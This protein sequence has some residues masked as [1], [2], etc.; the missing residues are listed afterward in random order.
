VPST[1]GFLLPMSVTTP[2]DFALLHARRESGRDRSRRTV[3]WMM[4][5]AV[6]IVA[7]VMALLWYLNSFETEEEERRRGADAQWLEQVVQFHFR[8]LE[9]DLQVLARQAALDGAPS[10]ERAGQGGASATGGLLWRQNGVVLDHGWVQ[11]DSTKKT[12]LA[13]ALWSHQWSESGANQQ[14]LSTLQDIA[15][16]LRRSTYAGP[17]RTAAGEVTDTVWLAVPYFDGGRFEGMY[18][19]AVSLKN[20]LDAVVP[21]WFLRSQAVRLVADDAAG[22]GQTAPQ[23]YRALMNLPGTD[24]MVE[25]VPQ[26][27]Q[28]SAVPRVFFLVALLFLLGMLV[29]LAALR[30]D[31]VKRQQVQQQLEAEVTLRTAMESSVT[32]GLRAWDMQGR[33]LYV[34]EAFCAIVGYSAF[35]LIG[36]RAPL[37]YWPPDQT[38]ELHLL[39][40]EII[41]QGTSRQGVEA[42][43]QHRDGRR[44][45]VLIHEAP[46]NAADGTQLGWMSSVVDISE[47]K[48]AQQLA[49]LQQEKLEA[50]GRLVAVGEVASTLAH[51]LNQPLGALSSFASGLLNRLRD[52][53][54]RP[55]EIEPV[56]QRMATLAERAGGVIQRVNA[57]ARKRELQ[58]QRVDVGAL[59]RR[60]VAGAQEQHTAQASL[61]SPVAPVWVQADALLLEHL[62]SN[63]CSNAMDWA[64]KG[65]GPALVRVA[66]VEQRDAQASS[67]ILSVADSGP[68]VPASDQAR[69]F[70]AFYSTKDGGMG[71]GLAICRSI[72]EA[73][74][75][76]IE[77]GR[78]SALGG[79]LFTVHLP[80]AAPASP[81]P[82]ADAP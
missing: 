6:L 4:G 47:R 37:P 16:G 55:E 53:N 39:H 66:L 7:A 32:T 41:T 79:A 58:L 11:Q 49:A 68:G 24:L 46:L 10:H 51:E 29:S 35:E 5:F 61:H 69:I 1:Q 18:V 17:M 78:D 27:A 2:P 60:V 38:D 43:F 65:S 30:R 36:A 45:D 59:L 56:V 62:V 73:H 23:R 33:V 34:N 14:S 15:R 48:R 63:L 44:I 72:V 50:S 31:F 74:H 67:V 42:E 25:V 28:A 20:A 9:D 3:L 77:V 71:M 19:V 40:S 21:P 54:I 75:G 12:V 57:F 52:G 22:T 70:D 80:L 26:E 8:R 13:P 81:L 82:A 64:L 76:R